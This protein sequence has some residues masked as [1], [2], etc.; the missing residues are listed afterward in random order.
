MKKHNTKKLTFVFDA[1][2]I[3]I[4]CGIGYCYATIPGGLSGIFERYRY[5]G[6]FI[7][8]YIIDNISTL[9]TLFN[10]LLILPAVIYM[11]YRSTP[12]K[13][14]LKHG[15]RIDAEFVEIRDIRKY[16][17]HGRV[18]YEWI[19]ICRGKDPRVGVWD[20]YES[21]QL[22]SNPYEYFEKNQ[23]KSVPVYVNPRNKKEYI[24]DIKGL[25]HI[26]Q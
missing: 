3:V 26:I 11:I 9:F 6:K 13:R 22:N 18:Y 25:Q 21:K 14:L 17:R 19:I 5:T 16:G 2:W 10:C 24:M 1:I 4:A 20:T 23:I 12:Y 15:L 7:S 8:P